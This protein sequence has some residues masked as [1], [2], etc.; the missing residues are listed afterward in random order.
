MDSINLLHSLLER[1]QAERDTAITV[2]RQ[3]EAL[4][5]QASAQADQLHA[6]RSDFDQ[7]WTLR[8]RQSGTRELLDCQQAFG[9][10][11]SQAID[12]QRNDSVHMGNRV[13]RA[14]AALM[15]RE[16]RVAAVRKL[17]ERREQELQRMAGRREQREDDDIAQRQH[18][19]HPAQPQRH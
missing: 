1:A 7:R 12:H 16:Q 5:R 18:Q 13:E 17:I 9:Q 6:Y 15:A 8:F 19:R 14:R 10:R 4:V 11:L 3:A 2:L